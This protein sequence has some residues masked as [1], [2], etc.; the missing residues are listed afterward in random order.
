M[1]LKT[2]INNAV[3]SGFNAMGSSANDG[4]Q[5]AITYTQVAVGS[6]D[7]TTGQRSTTT[8]DTTFDCIFYKVRDKEVDGIKIKINDIR[9][10]FPQDRIDFDPSA[11][12][13]ITLN[14]RKFE[15]IQIR[16]DPTSSVWVLFIRGV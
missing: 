10:V 6:Y 13:Y 7:P 14:S 8:T 4:I 16:E 9:L 12:D 3:K 11:D 5:T 15:I 2:A 1:G